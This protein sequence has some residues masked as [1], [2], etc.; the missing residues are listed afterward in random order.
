MVSPKK[1]AYYKVIPQ[2]LL[3]EAD[4]LVN[5]VRYFPYQLPKHCPYC[6][7][8]SF[9]Q[10]SDRNI[11]DEPRFQ[12]YF[13]K[14][15]F[16]QL[17]G[18]YFARMTR[19]ELWPDFIR[20]RLIGISLAKIHLKLKLSIH[21]C[22]VRERRLCLMME[23]MFPKLYAWWKPHHDYDDHSFTKEV[24]KEQQF[25]IRWLDERIN[26][27]TAACP[28]CGGEM[29]RVNLRTRALGYH[30][31]RPY[32]ACHKCDYKASVFKPTPLNKLKYM[33]LWIPYIKELT[34]GKS[35]KQIIKVLNSKVDY[36]ISI[37]TLLRWRKQFI[38]QM[39]LLALHHLA[40]WIKW[41][42]TRNKSAELRNNYKKRVKGNVVHK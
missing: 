4:A 29:R 22:R 31:N 14:H 28:L 25:F 3:A 23:E 18:T 34:L 2:H 37:A 40:Q 35:N 26:Q 16:S 41:Q 9:R 38:A 6:S 30:Q 36:N 1:P 42:R 15:E 5:Y 33:E 39:E 20:Y 12:C 24:T 21:A 8:D 32:L 13:C 27:Q 19:M 7:H 10:L 17:T 11:L